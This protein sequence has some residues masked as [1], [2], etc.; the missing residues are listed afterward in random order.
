[1]IRELMCE[2]DKGEIVRKKKKIQ[3]KRNKIKDGQTCGANDTDFERR[4][5]VLAERQIARNIYPRRRIIKHKRIYS[6]EQ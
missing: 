3:V 2:I 1:M 6:T 5:N 4:I